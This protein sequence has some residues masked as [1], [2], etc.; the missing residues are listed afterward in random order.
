M[1]IKENK[2]N[3]S[4]MII[5]EAESKLKLKTTIYICVDNKL[6]VIVWSAVY[7]NTV[8]ILTNILWNWTKEKQVPISFQSSALTSLNSSNNQSHA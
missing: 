8:E 4:D 3:I 5:C 1:K 2:Y 7:G 6:N